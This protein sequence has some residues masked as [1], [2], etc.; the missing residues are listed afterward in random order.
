MIPTQ[1]P[2]KTQS[3]QPEESPIAKHVYPLAPSHC[4]AAGHGVGGQRS[5]DRE[6][7]DAPDILDEESSSEVTVKEGH[8]VTLV[9][10]ARGSPK[11][12][13]SWKRE[14]G[15]RIDLNNGINLRVTNSE[16]LH[17][18]S[19]SRLHMGAYLCIASNE[20]PPS[21]SKRIMLNV[22]FQPVLWI[23]N[24]LVGVA[25][26]MSVT[27]ECHTEAFPRSINYWTDDKGKMILS[28]GRFD[29]VVTENSYRAY[30]RL[31][32]KNVQPE[33]YMSYGCYAKN[34]L[35]ETNGSI[36]V[37]G[38]L[39][40]SGWGRGEG[41]SWWDIKKTD[42]RIPTPPPPLPHSPN[43]NV[44]RFPI[45]FPFTFLLPL[46]LTSYTFLL[47][48][49]LT[50]FP[51]H[52]FPP[53]LPPYLSFPYPTP[54]SPSFLSRT[55][56][57]PFHPSF[58]PFRLSPPTLTPLPPPFTLSFTLPPPS[59]TLHSY[60]FP[61]S[62]LNPH[63]PHPFT[64]HSYPFP[65]SP[66]NPHPLT[67]SPLTRDTPRAH[68]EPA[69][70]R[71]D[72]ARRGP[73]QV[74]AREP[75]EEPQ[76]EGGPRERWRE[77]GGRQRFDDDDVVSTMTADGYIEF[78]VQKLLGKSNRSNRKDPEN[79]TRP[80]RRGQ[81]HRSGISE[82][83]PLHNT[84]PTSSSPPRPRPGHALNASLVSG[85]LAAWLLHALA[86]ARQRV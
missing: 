84:P 27:L 68:G 9:C 19:V 30:M 46:T 42:F 53:S 75:D 72:P 69:R 14:D 49:P 34:S 55:L 44:Q 33:D 51:L 6:E 4:P 23:P 67:H 77:E 28:S 54:L 16:V 21:V 57:T 11:P 24:Q 70:T 60:P 31:K 83:H 7:K 39:V 10:R 17:I 35:G 52:P 1:S 20:V 81:G 38:E 79:K 71:T 37:Y 5:T 3:K 65:L 12:V 76:A 40:L 61:S 82:N 58:L 86:A 29:T 66:P 22:Q 36:K 85:L 64:L 59:F 43:P 56:P 48:L 50:L 13:I 62:R 80:D 26:G 74:G 41:P 25:L 2:H 15:G 78:D 47:S 18:P 73:G 32:I 8:D 63:P 45:P